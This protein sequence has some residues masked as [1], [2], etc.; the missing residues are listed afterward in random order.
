MMKSARYWDNVLDTIKTKKIKLKKRIFISENWQFVCVSVHYS[1]FFQLKDIQ[2][3]PV[4]GAKYTVQMIRK[5]AFRDP[6]RLTNRTR[7]YL[8]LNVLTVK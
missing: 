1:N 6:C 7:N 2:T 5:S 8:Y 4:R 3:K